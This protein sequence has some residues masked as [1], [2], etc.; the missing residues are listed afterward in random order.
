LRHERHADFLALL[1][2]EFLARLD[3]ARMV[4]AEADR[5]KAAEEISTRSKPSSRMKCNWPGLRC[6]MVSLRTS[7][8][9]SFLASETD[10]RAGRVGASS[11]V[12]V[13]VI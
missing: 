7:P 12:S 8:R 13:I 3:D 4:V 6:A 11:I 2:L 5:T 10:S 1:I 9:S